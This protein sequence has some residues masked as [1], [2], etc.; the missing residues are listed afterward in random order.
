MALQAASPHKE[1][2]KY[3]HWNSKTSPQKGHPRF[4]LLFLASHA[5]LQVQQ[6]KE[7]ASR[8]RG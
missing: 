6:A 7:A 1:D 5:M 3:P 4:R 8:L 2:R